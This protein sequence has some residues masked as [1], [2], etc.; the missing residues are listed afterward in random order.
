VRI[1][2]AGFSDETCTFCPD[3]T[4]IDRYEPWALRGQAILD[5]NRGIPTYING[6]MK[7]LEAEGAEIVPVTY[8]ARGPGGFTSWLT[9]DCYEKYANEIADG[10]RNAGRLDGVLLSLHGAMAASGVPK[11]EAELVRRCRAAVGN[12]PIMVTL[13]LHANEDHELT[14]A[15]DGVFVL[16]TYPHIDSEEIGEVAARCMVM[17]VRGEFK[18]AQALRKPGLVSASIYQASGYHPMKVVFD[19]CREW[20]KNEKVYCVSVAPGYAYADVEDIGMSV[21]AVTNGDQAL[22]EKVAQDVSHLA[23]SLREAF[24]RPLPKPK[25]AVAEVMRLVAQGKGPIVIADGADRTGDSTHVLAELIAQDAKNW[26]IPGIADPKAA[27]QLQQHHKVGDKVTLSIGG[28]ASEFSGPP[29]EITGTVE[30]MGEP[31]YEM[32]GP[33][34]KGAKINEPFVARIN[35]GDNRHVGVAAHMRGALDSAALT[36]IGVDVK[37]LDIITL[38]DRVHHRAYWEGFGATSFPID[39]PGIGPADLSILHYDNAP[40]DAFP[41]GSKWRK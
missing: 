34:M 7:V 17:T 29:V 19:R 25:E 32:I 4:T 38:K 28:W 13:D 39:A 16:K 8:A 3:P 6:Y 2:I 11:P 5:Q 40:A 31:A 9:N 35:L 33:M 30:Y 12:V 27:K 22:A 15:S 36:A 10:L 1:A 41:I 20:E 26:A 18:P 24:T 23:W 37:T 21:V 14:D